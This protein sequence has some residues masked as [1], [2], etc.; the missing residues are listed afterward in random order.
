MG[1][2]PDIPA[3]VAGLARRE[4]GKLTGTLMRKLGA[5]SL[6]FAEDCVQE[7]LLAALQ[8][9]P[10]SGVPDHPFSWLLMTAQ[11]RGID[12]LRRHAMQSALEPRVST[13]ME[14]L[15][16]PS[17][18]ALIGDEELL[19]IAMC[20]APRL[21]DDARQ[22]LA[23][24]CVCGFSVDEI[25][26]AFLATPSAIA[27]RLVRA[28]ARLR[29]GIAL[30]APGGAGFQERL[31]SILRTIYLL[32][33]EGYSTSGG[34][35]LIRVEICSEALRL[36]RLLL[37]HP[38]TAT[39]E[40]HALCAL[41]LFQH[42]RHRARVSGDGDAIPLEFQDRQLWDRTMIGEGF[43]HMSLAMTGDRLTAL[44]LEAGIASVHA[45]SP[46][47]DD[48]DWQQL[49]RYYDALLELAPSP[50]VEVNRAIAVAMHQGPDE[51]LRLLAPLRERPDVQRYLPFHL[52]VGELCLRRGL[53]E[54]A[55]AAFTDAL[56]L[57]M[58]V[59]ERK[60]IAAK[61]QLAADA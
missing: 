29:D 54:R 17:A 12:R 35:Q 42:A 28:K 44:H 22:V 56:G 1:S 31:P 40:A 47:F 57:A 24:K 48:T 2:G 7:A 36:C 52:A 10:I 30:E 39:P 19:L 37:A 59:Q 14:A 6:S 25:A 34:T 23:L 46:R 4:V 43:R 49:G 41:M 60:L 38:M 51:G 45:S 21:E 16:Q 33:N 53:R 18:D 15:R 3:L 61:L 58:S 27:Q 11:N 26:R 50:V 8:S 32:F 5:G 20:C 13:W 55:R 9:W